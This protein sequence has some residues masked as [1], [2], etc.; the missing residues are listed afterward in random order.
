MKRTSGLSFPTY[1][2]RFFRLWPTP[3]SV[4]PLGLP[5]PLAAFSSF[6]AFGFSVIE[7]GVLCRIAVT[8]WSSFIALTGLFGSS[9]DLAVCS[10]SWRPHSVQ[11][12]F[13][14]LPSRD[15]HCLCIAYM[16]CITIL[17][18]S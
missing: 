17:N 18:K 10:Q 11:Y 13:Q 9:N 4:A 14:E 16:E 8:F 12:T 6:S 5:R 7:S 2:S 3:S 15:A 1:Y